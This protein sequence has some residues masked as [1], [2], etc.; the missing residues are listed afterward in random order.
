[1]GEGG[2]GN[3]PTRDSFRRLGFASL[4]T[5][6][7]REGGY[8]QVTVGVRCYQDSLCHHTQHVRTF[9]CLHTLVFSSHRRRDSVRACRG[10]G[11]QCI[12]CL[13]IDAINSH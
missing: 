10:K 4:V 6:K 13:D 5:M 1:M 12:E 11:D 3:S 8:V 7:Q 2:G 9:L